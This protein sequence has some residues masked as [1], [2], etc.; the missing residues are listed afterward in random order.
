MRWN[1]LFRGASLTV[2]GVIACAQSPTIVIR[3]YIRYQEDE[4]RRVDQL[5]LMQIWP[6]RGRK[7]SRSD[8]V[9]PL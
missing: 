2:L 9:T 6:L 4:D 5:N 7:G 8:P 1:E 3:E